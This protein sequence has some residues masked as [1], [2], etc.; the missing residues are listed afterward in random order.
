MTVLISG[1]A[2]FLLMWAVSSKNDTVR[3]IARIFTGLLTVASLAGMVLLFGV[4]QKAHWTSD[5][6]GM[7]F[8]MI[9]FLFCGIFTLIFG[10]LTFKTS[11][12][13]P[14]PPINLSDLLTPPPF[15]GK[16]HPPQ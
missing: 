7:L 10:S 16:D 6:P 12:S 4:G 14:G 5:G 11:A 8:I 9:G 3:I 1:I 15:R 2:L 13:E